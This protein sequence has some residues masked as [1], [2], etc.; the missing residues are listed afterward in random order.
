MIRRP[1]RSTLFPYTTLFRSPE[2]SARAPPRLELDAR[3]RFHASREMVLHQGHFR[4][5]VSRCDEVGFCVAAGDDDMEASSAVAQRRNDLRQIEIIVAQCDVEFVE[6]DEAEARIG[7]EL[8]RL[9]PGALGRGDVALEILGFPGE[10]LTHGVPRHLL[11]EFRK[12]ITFRRVPGT[13]DELHDANAV[14]A[15]QHAQRQAERRRG[16]AFAGAGVYDE[17]SLFDGLFRDFGVLNGLALRH[18]GAMALTLRIVDIL[19]HFVSFTTI[20]NPAIMRTTRSART[21]IRWFR[22]P[23]RSRKRRANSLSGTMPKP[24]SL[25]TRTTGARRPPSA[26][27]RRAISTSKSAPA[28]RR[29]DSHRVRQSTTTGASPEIAASAADKSWG[30]STVCQFLLRRKR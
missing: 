24:T 19:G 6:N 30:A 4:H 10:A 25:E 23:C 13:L 27:S 3:L 11:A 8:Q 9:R 15:P 7:H 2:T 16:F 14:A 26:A 12:R 17:K 21:A 5:Q 18:L 29:F 1:P 20:C 22:R 28:S